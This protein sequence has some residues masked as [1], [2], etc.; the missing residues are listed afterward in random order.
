MKKENVSE[1]NK[2]FKDLDIV[3]QC[4]GRM[5]NMKDVILIE[6]DA[7]FIYTSALCAFEKKH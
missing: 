3:K 6:T 4:F 1:E 2:I 5:I 7:E